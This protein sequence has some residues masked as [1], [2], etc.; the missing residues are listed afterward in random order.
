[1]PWTQVKRHRDGVAAKETRIA[2][3]VAQLSRC[4]PNSVDAM[5]LRRRIAKARYQRSLMTC[6]EVNRDQH[7]EK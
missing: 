1:M 7:G 5:N 4:N 6:V 2:E 3:L